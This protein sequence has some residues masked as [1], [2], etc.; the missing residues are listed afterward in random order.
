MN[1]QTIVAELLTNLTQQALADMVPCSQS[2]I[3]SFLSGKRGKRPSLAIGMRLLELH[4]EHCGNGV[5]Y[6]ANQDCIEDITS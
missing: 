4:S 6:I 5:N 2:A 3:A 1:T